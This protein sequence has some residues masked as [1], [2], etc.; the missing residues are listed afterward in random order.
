VQAGAIVNAPDGSGRTPL[1]LVLSA[2]ESY[3]KIAEQS[4]SMS[5]SKVTAFLHVVRTLMAHGSK[6]DSV[7]RDGNTARGRLQAVGATVAGLL[8]AGSLGTSR[9]FPE[10]V[11]TAA[12]EFVTLGSIDPPESSTL[13]WRAWRKE[14]GCPPRPHPAPRLIVYVHMCPRVS[15]TGPLTECPKVLWTPD[16]DLSFCPLCHHNFSFK[17]RKHHV[18]VAVAT[19]AAVDDCGADVCRR[20]RRCSA[21]SADSSCVTAAR[22]SAP[23]CSPTPTST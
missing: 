22:R 3:A 13:L 1:H 20:C 18:R 11:L 19:F 7:D 12:A 21:A 5:A 9:T 17:I 14:R 6:L 16:S 4:S 10:M 15:T 8:P 2:L 23:T